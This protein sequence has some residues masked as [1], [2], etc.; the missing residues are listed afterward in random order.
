MSMKGNDKFVMLQ[1]QIR[2]N[3][4]SVQDYVSELTDWTEEI[5]QKD[6]DVKQGKGIK[7]VNK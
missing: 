5:S 6:I 3:S 2:Q 4:Y 1:N 7:V